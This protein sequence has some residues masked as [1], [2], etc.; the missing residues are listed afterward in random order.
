MK[1]KI[2]FLLATIMMLVGATAQAT[3][4]TVTWD[5]SQFQP[6]EINLYDGESTTK[7]GV[8]LKAIKG[9]AVVDPED[10]FMMIKESAILSPI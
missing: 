4:K 6:F 1:Q 3:T 7:D 9:M 5:C 2:R 10:G 8:T